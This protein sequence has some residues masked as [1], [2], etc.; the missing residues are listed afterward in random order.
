[1][2]VFRNLG[3][4]T[5]DRPDDFPVGTFPVA[6][7]IGDLN[8]DG[9]PDLVTA[10]NASAN[11]SILINTGGGHFAGKVDRTTGSLPTG[12]MMG[13]I[14]GDGNL[15]L[16]VSNQR[17]AT[18][19]VIP[20]NGDGTFGPQNSYITGG[21]PAAVGLGDLN[22][23]G[24]LDIIVSLQ[25]ANSVVVSLVLAM[26]HAMLQN[27]NGTFGFG[28]SLLTPT[29]DG[30]SAMVVR[31]FDGDGKLDVA[32]ANAFSNTVSILLG[33]GDGKFDAK[34][35]FST[36][37]FPIALAA[38]DLNGD[39][40]PDLAVANGDANSVSVLFNTG[41]LTTV[42]V[43][44]PAARALGLVLGAPRPNPAHGAS[45]VDLVLPAAGEASVGVFDAAGRQVR[46][47][48]KRRALP[49]GAHTF[50]WDGRDGSGRLVKPGVFFVRAAAG[51]ETATRT[52]V[53][54][55]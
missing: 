52:L 17:S 10:N 11:I 38:D 41:G 27:A 12:V 14:N 6:L 48:A 20:G 34:R 47:L 24:R 36:G 7:A 31:D 39:G 26:L 43:P 45:E 23:D 29:G 28:A 3:D 8:H 22:G 46:V 2:S 49:A 55:R 25:A 44:P 54:G 35:D 51:D 9:Q 1:M 32:V 4:G 40:R 16:V 53:L 5:F 42:D 13:D 21:A 19:T 30:P 33:H 50:R 37:I 18:I 15:D